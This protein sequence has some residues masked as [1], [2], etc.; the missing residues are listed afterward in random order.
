MKPEERAEDARR[1]Y[2]RAQEFLAMRQR[3]AQ[4]IDGE[5]GDGQAGGVHEP[6]S[7]A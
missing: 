7:I 2:Q 4:V 5:P 1:L 3:E 6:G